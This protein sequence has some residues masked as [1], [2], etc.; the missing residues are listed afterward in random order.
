MSWE[1]VTNGMKA[2]NWVTLKKDKE[3][4]KVIIVGEPIL[5]SNMFKGKKTKQAVFPVIHD[6]TLKVM[7]FGKIVTE[8]IR[9]DWDNIHNHEVT[10]ERMGKANDDNTTYH[11]AISP[12]PKKLSEIISATSADDVEEILQLASKADIHQAKGNEEL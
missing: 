2:A 6:G 1:N 9:D 5:R 12:D 7:A 4:V 3:T 11:I 10:I 8:R